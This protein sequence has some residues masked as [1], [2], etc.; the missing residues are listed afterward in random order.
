[1][2]DALALVFFLLA[3]LFGAACFNLGMIEGARRTVRRILENISKGENDG[4]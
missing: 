4:K 3:A 2:N 1:M